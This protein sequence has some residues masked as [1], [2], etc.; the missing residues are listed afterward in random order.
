V[1]VRIRD[2]KFKK[3]LIWIVRIL[4]VGGIIA[5]IITLHWLSLFTSS[6]ALFSTYLPRMLSKRNIIY[7]PTDIQVI[8]TIFVFATLYLGEMRNYYYHFWWWD[9]MLHTFS[10]VI[11]GFFGFI[12]IYVLNREEDI[13]VILSP[14]F[15]AVFTFTFA[16]SIGVFWEIFEF[17]M[18]TIFGFNMQ[19]NG[20]Q[21]TMWDF[22]ADCIGGGVAGFYGYMYLKNGMESYFEKG[23]KKFISDNS[24]LFE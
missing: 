20:L 9:T 17:G 13:D 12:L 23:V 24:Q 15:V 8:I 21:D 3:L 2:I 1:V 18:D 11:L 19:K 4:L 16:V 22:I 6:L 10:G 14:I 7:L 5:N